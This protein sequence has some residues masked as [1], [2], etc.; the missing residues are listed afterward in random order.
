MV[1]L[2]IFFREMKDINKHDRRFAYFG[3][4]LV[5]LINGL[6][7]AGGGM[8]A[9]PLLKKVGAEQKKA[10]ATSIAL[11][12]P[13]CLFSAVLYLAGG[14]V[15]ISDAVGYLPAGAVGAIIGAFLLSKINDVW[16]KRIF[17][18]FI[19]WSGVRMWFR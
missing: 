16:L 9:V 19:I 7:G 14:K 6:L 1:F 11:I 18:L 2:P 13:L 15:A 12:L 8:L 10:H 4:V 17:A 5:G 3:S